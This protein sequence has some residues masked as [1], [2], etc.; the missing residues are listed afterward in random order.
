LGLNIFLIVDV[1]KNLL[2]A[3]L[4]VDLDFKIPEG[5]PVRRVQC[6]EFSLTLPQLI[7]NL[8]VPLLL[9]PQRLSNPVQLGSLIQ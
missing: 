2:V 1:V 6:A 3:D 8:I 9:I 4:E 5:A 7:F